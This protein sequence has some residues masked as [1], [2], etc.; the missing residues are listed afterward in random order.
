MN[1]VSIFEKKW[2]DLVFEGK[3]KEYGAYQLRRE[4]PVTTLKA[5]FF[6]FLLLSICVLAL[7]SFKNPSLVI[8]PD[9]LDETITPV[10][11]DNPFKPEPPKTDVA[12]PAGPNEEQPE[13]PEYIPTTPAE[14]DPEPPKDPAPSAPTS[15][16]GPG[17]GTI[18]TTPGTIPGTGPSTTT[19]TLPSDGPVSTNRLDS[20]PK[21]PGGIDNFYR[22]VG[23]NFDKPEINDVK[24]VSVIVSF[25][26]EKDGSMTDIKVM[27]D[28]GYGLG[29][30]AIRVL[31]SLKVKW[32][33]GIKDN[34]PVRTAYTLPIT[35][36]IE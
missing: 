31:K 24:T 25:V 12:P 23:N 32:E 5:L 7:S 36:N 22:Y 13:N 6:G 27:R 18:P 30:E 33:P 28:P 16:T 19:T 15:P 20:Q 35:V 14:A 11:M 29:K 34:K 3:N 8:T 26:I 21:Y 17:T 1:H 2:L 10:D 9:V 4:N